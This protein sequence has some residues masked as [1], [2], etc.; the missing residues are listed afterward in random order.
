MARMKTYLEIY[1]YQRQTDTDNANRNNR[2]DKPY[3][4]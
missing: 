2:I 1:Y 4:K 3:A